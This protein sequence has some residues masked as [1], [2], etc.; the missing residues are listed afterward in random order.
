MRE[1]VLNSNH[2]LLGQS[3][4]N[5]A[6]L[7]RLQGRY[8]EAENLY[9]RAKAIWETVLNT[10]HPDQGVIL[11]N[12]AEL[13]QAM[14]N[15]QKAESFY[16]RALKIREAAL[17]PDHTDVAQTL[18]NMAGLCFA[19]RKLNDAESLYRK[20]LTIWEKSFK[21]DHPI[22]VTTIHDFANL[23]F[24]LGKKQ[25][26]IMMEARV[27]EPIRRQIAREITDDMISKQ[28]I[29]L[30]SH[31]RKQAENEVERRIKYPDTAKGPIVI[32]RT[33]TVSRGSSS[34][35]LS[36]KRLKTNIQPVKGALDLVKKL[37]GVNFD[38]KVDEDIEVIINNQSRVGFI[39]Q[40][41]EEVIPQ[42]VYTTPEGYKGVH[43]SNLVAILVEAIKEQ[44]SEIDALKQKLLSKESSHG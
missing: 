15:Y 1:N 37:K 6:Q 19:T 30:T 40:E 35:P 11:N 2:P 44:Q 10:E 31:E 28:G 32:N 43:Y 22:V 34:S 23:L 41:V 39:A 21:L 25:E 38:W 14:G 12:L 20:G 7:Y 4:N 13:Y 26:A 33:I 36:D 9:L 18:K 3:F 8:N 29:D 24:I 16:N 42:I 5:L 17:G 27:N